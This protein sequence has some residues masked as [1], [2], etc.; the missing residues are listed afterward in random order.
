MKQAYEKDKESLAER[1]RTRFGDRSNV[2]TRSR[3]NFRTLEVTEPFHAT[4]EDER[5]TRSRNTSTIPEV[6]ELSDA[7]DEVEDA[8]DHDS[9]EA[10][11]NNE[12]IHVD[13][14]EAYNDDTE[15][16]FSEETQARVN[17]MVDNFEDENAS[18]FRDV[19]RRT[20]PHDFFQAR[21]STQRSLQGSRR[22]TF[23]NY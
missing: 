23:P 13:H 17:N 11:F 9:S 16:D 6:S 12:T 3:N 20:V 15:Y 19:D 1:N 7:E 4:D 21:T 5:N 14:Q 8:I 22:N 10:L 2:T 18:H